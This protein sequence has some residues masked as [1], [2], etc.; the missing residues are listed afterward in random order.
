VRLDATRLYRHPR[1]AGDFLDQE[2]K[3]LLHLQAVAARPLTALKVF[4]LDAYRPCQST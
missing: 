1:I 4:V 3:K 2:D